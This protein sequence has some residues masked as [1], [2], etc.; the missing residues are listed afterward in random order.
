MRMTILAAILFGLL[1]GAT[2]LFAA[3]VDSVAVCTAVVDRTCE[4]ASDSFPSNVGKVF[5]YTRIMGMDEGGSVTHRWIFKGQVMAETKL[6]V[7]GPNWRTWSSKNIDPLWS[8]AWKVEIVNNA[9]NS[10]M[11]ILEFTVTE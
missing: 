8:G 1:F 3:S 6:N 11:D 9:D 4:G 10:V 7:G 2:Q 5:A